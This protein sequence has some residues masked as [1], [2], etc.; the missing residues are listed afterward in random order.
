MGIRDLY[1]CV[2]FVCSDCTRPRHL[3]SLSEADR[4]SV[5][6][7]QNVKVSKGVLNIY[8]TSLVQSRFE[9]HTMIEFLNVYQIRQN[10][11]VSIQAQAQSFKPQLHR[12]R[13]SSVTAQVLTERYSQDIEAVSANHQR[14]N[15]AGK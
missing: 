1:C 11:G 12:T 3:C 15:D 9:Q 8:S 13:C 14:Q 6:L 10:L 5:I 7:A 2:V 4:M